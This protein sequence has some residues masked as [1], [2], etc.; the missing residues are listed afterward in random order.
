MCS[1]AGWIIRRPMKANCRY[2]AIQAA[3]WSAVLGATTIAP[4]Y[5]TPKYPQSHKIPKILRAFR[6]VV[7]AFRGVVQAFSPVPSKNSLCKWNLHLL[8]AAFQLSSTAAADMSMGS[9]LWSSATLECGL[10]LAR[11][12]T[13]SLQGDTELLEMKQEVLAPLLQQ[14][15]PPTQ[16]RWPPVPEN[17]IVYLHYPQR[18]KVFVCIEPIH[19]TDHNRLLYW[20]QVII[21][22]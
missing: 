6:G 1:W 5:V 14:P 8:F 9:K 10:D 2:S 21:A 11:K 18:I 16:R 3:L 17:R 22:T 15:Q 20:F 19:V 12:A 7:Q 13:L 4:I